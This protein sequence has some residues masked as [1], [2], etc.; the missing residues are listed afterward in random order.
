MKIK[1]IIK[2]V[3]IFIIIIG[4]FGTNT[5]N[6][7]S[8]WEQSKNWLQTGE[9]QRNNSAINESSYTGFEELAGLV[10]GLGVFIILIIGTILGIRYIMSTPEQKAQLN[11]ALIAYL[12]GTVIILGASAVWKL[13]VEIFEDIAH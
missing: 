6:A 3:L 11:T 8:I 13:A 9:S 1:N 5:V 10:W 12:V 4:A 7:N 2:I